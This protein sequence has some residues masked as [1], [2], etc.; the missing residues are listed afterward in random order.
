MSENVYESPKAELQN[1]SDE[2]VK[3]SMSQLFFSFQGRIRRGQYWFANVIMI[4]AMIV[5]MA[6]L[7][8]LG[9]NESIA[10]IVFLV[11]YIP[12]I[13]VSLAVQAKRWHDRNKSAWWI[14]INLIPF[15]GIWAF[16]ENG[17]LA[18]DGYSNNYGPP[19][20]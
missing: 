6:L 4:I 14:L 16:V 3:V 5:L 13:W 20:E 15:G 9:V 19:S 17:C 10:G 8:V 7:A 11:F 18:G 2:A 1:E 12:L